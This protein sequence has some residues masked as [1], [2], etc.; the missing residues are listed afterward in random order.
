MTAEFLVEGACTDVLLMRPTVFLLQRQQWEAGFWKQARSTFHWTHTLSISTCEEG[1]LSEMSG[2]WHQE[3]KVKY[4]EKKMLNCVHV[5]ETEIVT[6]FLVRFY[7][8][9]SITLKLEAE[10]ITVLEG[11][12]PWSSAERWATVAS[13]PGNSVSC[14]TA[15]GSRRRACPVCR[16]SASSVWAPPRAA[17]SRYR[18]CS[19]SWCEAAS[20]VQL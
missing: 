8:V 2:G 17:T 3:L 7:N 19:H 18:W 11:K 9:Q 13:E 5:T 10:R 12:P 15:W 1:N 20:P 6:S 14:P 16:L 4:F